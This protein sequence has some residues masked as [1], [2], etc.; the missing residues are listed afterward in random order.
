MRA[1]GEL[2]EASRK[3][4]DALNYTG[5][6]MLEYRYNFESGQWIFLEINGRF[7]GSLPL[8]LACGVDFPLYLYQMLVE[9][10]TEFPQRYPL[11]VCCRNIEGD[12]NWC[13]EQ[14]LEAWRTRR[15]PTSL[16]RGAVTQAA[17]FVALREH[18]DTLVADDPMPAA[19]EIAGLSRSLGLTL[20]SRL[21]LK[22]SDTRPFRAA[23]R[24]RAHSALKT[25]RKILIVCK[26]NICRSPFAQRAIE[27]RL[28]DIYDVRSCGYFP[29]DGRSCPANGISA[30]AEVGI[31]LST[32]RS[33]RMTDELLRSADVI[34]VF[35]DENWRTVCA[36]GIE[37]RRKTHRL[38]A[39]LGCLE[40][41][42]PFGGSEE[43]FRRVYALIN[44]AGD[45]LPQPAA[46]P[47]NHFSSSPIKESG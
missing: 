47:V 1:E 6:A 18:F 16:V 26:G 14:L 25:A 45:A 17:R 31:D 12:A 11:G 9:G 28:G 20:L 39:L 24:H 23:R 33:Q 19:S 43:D 40:I 44:R 30:A 35:D 27:R 15:L 21:K 42:D 46:A 32:H 34:F 37:I 8:A 22:C 29:V 2:L 38:G 13:K 3:I 4:I 7:W 5:V 41:Q 10:R 36:R